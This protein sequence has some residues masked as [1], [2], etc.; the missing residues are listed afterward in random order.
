ML[1][2]IAGLI[3]WSLA[4]AAIYGLHEVGCANDWDE[5]SVGDA[6]LQRVVQV[7]LWLVSIALMLV[8]ALWLRRCRLQAPEGSSERWLGLIGE[9]IGWA[10]FAA[11]IVTFATTATTSVCV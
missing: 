5:M 7:G 4:F 11:T 9:T 6:S 1:R 8:L 10:G 2:A 3:G